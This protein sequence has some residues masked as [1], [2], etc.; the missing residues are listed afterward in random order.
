MAQTAIRAEIHHAFD[1]HLT[2]RGA[3]RLRQCSSR[4]YAR[5]R[6]APRHRTVRLHGGPDRTNSG[7][8]VRCRLRANAMDVGQRDDNALTCRD[9]YASNTCHAVFLSLRFRNSRTF[10]HNT[11]ARS[12]PACIQIRK[13]PAADRLPDRRDSHLRNVGY[14]LF[15]PRSRGDQAVGALVT[16]AFISR[17]ITDCQYTK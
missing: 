14:V 15:R 17:L 4:R 13:T 3:G 6:R 10:F 2:L 7:A 8:D 9:V 16:V 1:V 5:A 12:P 11:E